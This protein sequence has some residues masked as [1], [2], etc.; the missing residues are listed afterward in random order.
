MTNFSTNLIAIAILGFSTF[1]SNQ[2]SK[3]H[4]E[5][6][7]LYPNYL[8]LYYRSFVT[9]VLVTFLMIMYVLKKKEFR[10][11]LKMLFNRS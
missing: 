11:Y 8:L 2:L 5:E 7:N 3:Y 1:N 6:L 9:P 4:P 10:S